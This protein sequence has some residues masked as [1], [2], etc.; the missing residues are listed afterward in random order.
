MG[1]KGRILRGGRLA[2]REAEAIL[3]RSKPDCELDPDAG[4]AELAQRIVASAARQES[5]GRKVEY[6]PSVLRPA[7]E[8]D[9]DADTISPLLWSGCA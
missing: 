4:F 5:T 6:F 9:A 8:G 7:A 2:K 3:V 1:A